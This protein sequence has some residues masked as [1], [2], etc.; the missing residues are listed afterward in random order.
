MGGMYVSFQDPLFPHISAQYWV[1][2]GLGSVLGSTIYMILKQ[3]VSESI[4]SSR[5]LVLTGV[6]S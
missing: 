1:G 4:P 5:P 6:V 3:Y 2:P